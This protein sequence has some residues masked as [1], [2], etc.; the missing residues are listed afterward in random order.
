MAVAAFRHMAVFQDFQGLYMRISISEYGLPKDGAV[1][2]LVA[3]GGKMLDAAKALDK[4]SKGAIGKALAGG[5]FEGDSGQW[6]E[7]L[8]PAGVD[9]D[10]VLLA[11]IGEGKEADAKAFENVG[12]NATQKLIASGV[13]S[14]TLMADNLPGCKLSAEEI[15]AHMAFGANLGGYRFDKYRTTLKPAQK[16]SLKAVSVSVAGAAKARSAYKPLSAIAEGVFLTRDLVS[17]PGNVLHPETLAAE[18]RKLSKSGL[19]VEVLGEARMR[20][21]GMGALLGVGQGSRKESQLVVMR[22]NGAGTRDKPVAFV[23]K[24]VTFDTGGISL[25]PGPG[26]EAMKWDMG[27]AGTVIGLM[28]ALAGR[29]AKVNA[30]GVVGLVEN[31]PDGDAQRPGDIVTS[32]SGQTIEIHNTDAE[33]RLVLADALWYTQDRF[34]PQ[35]MVDLATLTGAM[36]ISLGHENAGLFS[37]DDKLAERLFAAGKDVGEGVW[38]MPLADAYD[39]K[40]NC[41]IADMKNIGGRDAGSITAAQFLQRFVNKL[42]W[43]HLD[44]A[45]V[46][47]ADKSSPTVPKGGAGWGVRLLDRLVADHY[48]K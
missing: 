24:G 9:A 15:A 1:V 7:I 5:R 10:R 25:K 43:A 42:P 30:I 12:G 36:I 33:G 11:G 18:C 46:A 32:M 6:L 44:I 35:F 16:P 28:K 47:W 13:A 21:L 31:M 48:E 26:M 3:K 8:A 39:K 20:R 41:D 45:G 17:E 38:R 2:A 22:W 14:L 23:G 40:L 29:K 37:N 34:K 27:G 19:K 4:A